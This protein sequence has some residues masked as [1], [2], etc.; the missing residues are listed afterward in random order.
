MSKPPKN[1]SRKTAVGEVATVSPSEADFSEVL[2]LIDAAKA[3]AIAAV[4][5]ALIDLYWELGEY[6][7]RQG[8]RGRLGAGNG[9]DPGR[10]HREAAS[11]RERL[12]RPKSLA[13]DAV[14][15]RPTADRQNS[16]PLVTR[17][18]VDPQPASS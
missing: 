13:D 5:T 4:N 18:V 7:S 3:R 2:R 15:S 8:R 11:E 16:S 6:I 12:F 10:A 1:A 17:I 9:E 14:L